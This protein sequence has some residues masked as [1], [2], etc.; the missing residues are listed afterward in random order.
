MSRFGMQT[1]YAAAGSW[2]SLTGAGTAD[3]GRVG[4]TGLAGPLALVFVERSRRK[5]LLMRLTYLPRLL[6]VSALFSLESASGG[7]GGVVD[8]AKVVAS[9]SGAAVRDERGVMYLVEAPEYVFCGGQLA[10]MQAPV[11]PGLA[12]TGA[13]LRDNRQCGRR[14]DGEA[15]ATG[16]GEGWG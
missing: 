5:T 9:L 1:T 13:K 12:E 7:A 4:V 2:S 15:T 16:D 11:I 10:D 3:S 14:G 8:M 6:R